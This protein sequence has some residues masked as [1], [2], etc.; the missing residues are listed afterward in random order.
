MSVVSLLEATGITKRF[1]GITALDDVSITVEDGE[2]VGLIGPNGAG[3]TTFFN[4]L[5][6]L[7]RPEP[8][9]SSSSAGTSPGSPV[10]RRS[11]LG[12]ARTFQRIELFAGMTV[13]D[14]L[15][16]AERARLGTGRF[17]K[18]V[19]NLSKPTSDEN[20]RTDRT[21]ALLGL[22]DVAGQPGGGAEPR[23]GP[24]RRGRPGADDRGQAAPAR[25]A[26]VGP[27]RP[28]DRGARRHPPRG[29]GRAGDRGAARG[30][31]RRVRAELLG[32]A[33]GA[34]LR[35]PDRHR[36]DGR[37]PGRRRVRRAYLGEMV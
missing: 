15:L 34:R 36:P 11:R 28:R 35:P 17:W 29:A 25:R 20:E 27:R 32:P 26:V 33:L 21:L 19:L 12:F 37:G 7:L 8:A 16:V 3:K 14:H 4:C 9:R 1:S 10:Y 18:D 31:R 22:E 30:A 24:P 13:R 23:S 5:L 2:S 6:G